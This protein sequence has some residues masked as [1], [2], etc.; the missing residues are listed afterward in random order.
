M[1]KGDLQSRF[2]KYRLGGDPVPADVKILLQHRAE[3]TEITLEAKKD[4]TPW[5]D[6]SYL[7]D[8]DRA[9]PDITANVRAMAEVCALIVFIAADEEGQYLG[10]WRG[11]GRRPV[12]KSPL[13]FLDNEGQFNL[14]AG[15]TFAEALLWL[16]PD[17]EEFGELR[18][19]FVSLGIEV[20]AQSSDDLAEPKE[21]SP[22]DRLHRELFAR[23]RG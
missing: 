13:V 23:Y 2:S 7:S 22:P 14:C 15:T 21:T 8:A 6:T 20:E 10:Y 16:R 12:A 18:D 11:P 3:R 1:K 19:W 4:W 17:E 9:N 5:L